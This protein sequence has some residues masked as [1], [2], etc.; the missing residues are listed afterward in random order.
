[1]SGL[2]ID[3]LVRN[4]SASGA[5]IERDSFSH[6]PE[7]FCFEIARGRRAHRARIARR[8]VRTA[9]L[10]FKDETASAR[11]LVPAGWARRLDLSKTERKAILGQIQDLRAA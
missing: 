1:L 5:R 6:P 3:C 8:S 4:L 9:G 2:T 11:E 10:L 7:E